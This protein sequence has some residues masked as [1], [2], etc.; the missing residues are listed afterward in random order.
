MIRVRICYRRKSKSKH[1]A[2]S[3]NIIICHYFFSVCFYDIAN[4]VLALSD[5]TDTEEL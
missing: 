2:L 5:R 1:G 3:F 4:D